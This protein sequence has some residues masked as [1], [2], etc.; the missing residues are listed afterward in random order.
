M[1]DAFDDTNPVNFRFIF[2]EA[3]GDEK[4]DGYY[5]GPG[6]VTDL[7]ITGENGSYVNISI[8]IS[9]A[10]PKSFVTAGS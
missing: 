2:D 7:N 5:E 6:F 4:I 10:G 9:A 3:T 1:Q 8:T